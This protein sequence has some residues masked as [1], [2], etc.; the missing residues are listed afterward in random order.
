[1]FYAID[2]MLFSPGQVTITALETGESFHAGQINL[3]L[4]DASFV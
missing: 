3:K 1:D 2:P 4:L